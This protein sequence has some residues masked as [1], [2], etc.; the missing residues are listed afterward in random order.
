MSLRALLV[1]PT[2]HVR[3]GKQS[4]SVRKIAGSEPSGSPGPLCSE[5]NSPADAARLLVETF[6]QYAPDGVRF[7]QECAAWVV[8]SQRKAPTSW[9]ERPAN[10][11]R[12]RIVGVAA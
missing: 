4:Y 11:K 3:Y 7:T 6:E 1:K 9:V 8:E 12:G 2:H 5:G 10:G